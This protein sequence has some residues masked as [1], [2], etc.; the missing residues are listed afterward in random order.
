[1]VLLSDEQFSTFSYKIDAEDP[2]QQR[3]LTFYNEMQAY[4][5]DLKRK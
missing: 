4:R 2:N 5:A 3:F 1:M